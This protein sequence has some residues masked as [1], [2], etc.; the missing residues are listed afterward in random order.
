MNQAIYPA[1]K[2]KPSRIK[3]GI[4]AWLTWNIFCQLFNVTYKFSSIINMFLENSYACPS[5]L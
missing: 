3:L 1:F 5:S 4:L 2:F